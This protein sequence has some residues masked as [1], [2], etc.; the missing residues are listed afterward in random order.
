MNLFIND[1]PFFLLRNLDE[2]D[3]LLQKSIHRGDEIF[4]LKDLSGTVVITDVSTKQALRYLKE[5]VRHHYE[6]VS[7][8]ILPTHYDETKKLLKKQFRIIDAAGGVVS[9]D[10][11]EVLLIYRLKKWDLPKGK[12]DK[13][14]TFK[15]TAVREVEEETR[16][17]VELGKKITTTWHTY[18]IKNKPILKRT[19]WYMMDSLDDSRMKPQKAEFIEKI[20]WADEQQVSTLLRK[21][22]R[23]IRFVMK[24][25]WQLL[26]ATKN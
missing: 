9:N 17:K 7:F 18:A 26:K 8:R 24:N 5:L 21:S 6:D 12:I 20:G 22:Y 11:N 15:E 3:P 1:T 23:S 13:G 10:K 25:Y 14:E 16:V 2:A 4:E 19:K